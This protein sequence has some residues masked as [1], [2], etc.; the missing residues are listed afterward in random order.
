VNRVWQALI[1]GGVFVGIAGVLGYR[2]MATPM[3]FWLLL[4]GGIAAACV[5][6]SGF[7]LKEGQQLSPVFYLV[8]YPVNVAIYGGLAYL[9]L[10]FGSEDP[11]NASK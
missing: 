1:I 8:L 6:G 10:R 11:P 4:P 7:N 3:P 2:H 5:P 9:M